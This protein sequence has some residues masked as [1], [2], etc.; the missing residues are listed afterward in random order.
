MS[1]VADNNKRIAKN[2][3]FLYVRMFFLMLIGLFTS[4]VVLNALGINDYGLNNVVG[5]F[6]GMLVFLNGLLSQGS[7]RFLTYELGKGDFDRLRKTFSACLTI[8]FIMAVVVLLLGE[9]IGLWFVNTQLKINP[10]RMDAANWVYQFSLFS[11]FLSIMQTP[12]SA[13]VTS[14]E[15][16]SVYAYMSI[17]D[18]AMKLLIV[19]LLLVMDVDKLKLYSFFFFCT[20]VV[21]IIIYRIYC[22]RKFSECSFHFGY[23]KTLYKELFA[24]SGWNTIGAIAFLFNGEGVNVLL[25]IFFGT[26][27]NASRGIALTVANVVGQF[28]SNFQ[29]AAAP[30]IIKYYSQ[31]N[32]EEMNRLIVN[33]AKYS[34][35]LFIIIGIPIFIE[36]HY[37]LYLWLGQVPMYSA[38]FSR[39]VILQI[40]ITAIDG[41]IGRGIHAF[42]RMKLPNLT[43]AIIYLMVLPI[44]YVVLKLGA[45]PIT[46]YIVIVLVYPFALFCDLFIL[47][48]YSNISIIF[49]VKNVILKVILL[50]LLISVVPLFLHHYMDYGICRCLFVFSSSSLISCIIIYKWGISESVRII[51]INWIK[52]HINIR[53]GK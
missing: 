17:F 19:Y 10:E 25:N 16:M 38:W 5:G 50:T 52:N 53:Y 33:N 34:S 48:K 18:A 44:S 43:S 2:S 7:S 31:N 13:S 39:L 40:M 49:F 28:I 4:R 9:T 3:F 21:S 41:P 14:H 20:T 12:Y 6:V 36:I 23:D 1:A 15:K 42:G 46:I 27:V 45:N 30:Q 22:V 26:I 8:H 11:S 47:H 29:N 35:Y 24:Y 37:L 32:Y 51:V